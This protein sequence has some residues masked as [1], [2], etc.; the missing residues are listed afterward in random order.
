MSGF[1]FDQLF[2]EIK[3]KSG[4]DLTQNETASQTD[5]NHDVE[6]GCFYMGIDNVEAKVICDVLNVRETPSVEK[7]R[8]GQLHRGATVCVTGVCDDW[9]S[10]NLQ[11]KTCYICG[12]YTDFEAPTATVKASAL[13]VRKGPSVET[14]KIGSLPNGTQVKI[15]G[16][17][18]GWVKILHGKNI[19]YVSAEYLDFAQ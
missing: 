18:N 14:D 16:K 11:G 9:L 7:P 5:A 1:L 2:T 19:G 12:K 8:I 6:T 4:V 3:E 10:I 13:N 17:E 15:I